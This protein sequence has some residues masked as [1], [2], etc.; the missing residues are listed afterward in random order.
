MTGWERKA[1][2]P[3]H[4]KPARCAARETGWSAAA[5]AVLPSSLAF[6]KT[7]TYCLPNATL[8]RLAVSPS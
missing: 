5:P 4:V 3:R 8:F 1:V 7:S 6:L 2:S